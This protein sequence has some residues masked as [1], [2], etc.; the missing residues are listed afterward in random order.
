MKNKGYFKDD[1]HLNQVNVINS[2]FKLNYDKIL[3]L[4]YLEMHVQ[5]ISMAMRMNTRWIVGNPI[6]GMGTR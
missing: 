5:N 4:N 2:Y 6:P 1:M 3:K